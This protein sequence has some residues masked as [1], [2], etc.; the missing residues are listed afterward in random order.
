MPAI[1]FPTRIGL[2]LGA[3]L[4][5]LVLCYAPVA[6]GLSEEASPVKHYWTIEEIDPTDRDGLAVWA[7]DICHRLDIDSAAEA[8]N[9]APTADAVVGALTDSL[10]QD[11]RKEVADVCFEALRA[12]PRAHS[13]LGP[14]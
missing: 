4:L 8:I 2:L 11:I 13:D 14:R 6:F 12:G 9:V 3:G 5:G 7:R 10:P 1:S